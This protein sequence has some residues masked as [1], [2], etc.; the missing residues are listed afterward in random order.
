MDARAFTKLTP[1][2]YHV[3]SHDP[4]HES[5]FIELQLSTSRYL[6]DGKVGSEFTSGLCFTQ[7]QSGI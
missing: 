5:G 4:P 6:W 7:Q 1:F 2:S 3:G